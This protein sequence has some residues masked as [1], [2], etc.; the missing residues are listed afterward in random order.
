MI[1]SSHSVMGM[2]PY[3]TSKITREFL[4]VFWL[5]AGTRGL[6]P[7]HL[8]GKAVQ[9]GEQGQQLVLGHHL[10]LALAVLA[11]GKL[12]ALHFAIARDERVGDLGH[13]S[14]AGLEPHRLVSRVSLDAE[15]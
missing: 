13:L 7:F 6:A 1:F 5:C 3:I 8:I 12:V 9:L 10:G 15:A 4:G 11:H 14:F 2:K